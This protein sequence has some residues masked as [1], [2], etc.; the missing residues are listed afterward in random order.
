MLTNQ[1][2]AQAPLIDR[3]LLILNSVLCYGATSTVFRASYGGISCAA[4]V[5]NS[6]DIVTN[7]NEENAIAEIEALS[8]L[9]NHLNIVQ[10]HGVCVENSSHF[11]IVI[12]LVDGKD[13][14]LEKYLSSLH[15]EF[16]LWKAT[17]QKWSLDLLLA[18]DFLHN[19]D[20][21]LIHCDVKPANLLI[22]PYKT[23]LKLTDFG[24][25]KS[26]DRE[27]R[28]ATYLKANEGSARYRA[29]EVLSNSQIAAFTEKSDIYSASL[30]IYF[31]LTG[32][33]PDNDVKIDPRWLPTT[34]VSRLRWRKVSNFLER[35]W[36]HDAEQRPSA[37]ECAEF[38]SKLMEADEDAEVSLPLGCY[39]RLGWLTTNLR[40]V[41]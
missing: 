21:I 2:I 3:S 38:F 9:G 41:A 13:L 28:S 19:R 17:I 4:K 24:I 23:S 26:V 32:R 29:P 31:V 35:M 40:L 16:D 11:I 5:M 39:A 37:G 22:T 18:L 12:E 8:K 27:Q 6:E 33:R 34:M 7:Q 25:S 20:P 14:R 36:A 10:F 30:V 15:V 1:N